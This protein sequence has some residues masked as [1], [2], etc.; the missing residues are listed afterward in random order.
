VPGVLIDSNILI[1]VLATHSPWGARSDKALQTAA[2]QG[3][4]IIN[5]VIFAEV[6]VGFPRFEDANVAIRPI[7]I[8]E[9]IPYEAAF[10]AGQAY[11]AY[12]RNRGVRRSPLPDFFIGAHAA[13]RG[14]DL[15]TRDPSRYR[16]YFPT[17]RLIEP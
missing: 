8:R 15:L 11:R 14:Y 2:N 1:D 17:V 5:S 9:E 6:S 4:L 7:F 10:L 16:S 3:S 12:R 13:V